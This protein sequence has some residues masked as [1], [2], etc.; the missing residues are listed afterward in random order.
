L[1]SRHSL[2]FLLNLPFLCNRFFTTTLL[3]IHH[4]KQ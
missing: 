4:T 2:C 1:L 3:S